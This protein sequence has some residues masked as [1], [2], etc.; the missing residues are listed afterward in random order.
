MSDLPPPPPPVALSIAGSDP[1]GGAG[2]QADLKTF[3]QHGVYGAAAISLITVQDTRSVQRVDFLD[4]GLVLAQVDAVLKDLPP[5]AVKTGALGAAGV[6]EALAARAVGFDFP[7]VVD[8]V[9]AASDG[10]PLLEEEGKAILRDRLLP[11]ATLVTP[12]VEEAAFISGRSVRDVGEMKDVAKAIAEKGAASV[13]VTGGGGPEEAVDV[14]Y[15][16]GEFHTFRAKR[17]RPGE[18]HGSGCTLSAAITAHL[19]KGT[20]IV[21][22]VRA[23]KEFVTSAFLSMPRIGSGPAPL[24]HH[25]DVDPSASVAGSGGD[26]R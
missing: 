22:A 1:S 23:A 6:V 16:A 19:A 5:Q 2:I 15:T 4:S 7:L 21:D 17:D 14:L 13:L 25:A 8:P 3:H 10:T 9:F 12:N 24:N 20:Y 26:K 11:V 18:A